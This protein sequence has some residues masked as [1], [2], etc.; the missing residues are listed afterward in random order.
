MTD[1]S[2]NRV[3]ALY[4]ILTKYT[5]ELYQIS[6]QDILVNIMQVFFLYPRFKK[7]GVING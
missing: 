6:M 7:V 4:K 3:L 5:Y 1:F 2:K